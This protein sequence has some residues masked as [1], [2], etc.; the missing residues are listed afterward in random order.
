MVEAAPQGC[1][2][3]KAAPKNFAIFTGKELCWNLFFDK[4]A[5][6]DA[7]IIIKKRLK[8]KCFFGNIAKFLRAVFSEAVVRKNSEK[9]IEKYLCWSP[10]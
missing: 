1:P 5:C 4:V 9:F 10:F 3:K 7:C 8:H 6:L 2:I